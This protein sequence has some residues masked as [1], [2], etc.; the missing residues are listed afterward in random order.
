MY[1][2]TLIFRL[3]ICS[4][5]DVLQENKSLYSILYYLKN[6]IA[7]DCKGPNHRFDK[8]LVATHTLNKNENTACGKKRGGID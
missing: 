3:F 2:G 4:T 6:N 5:Q 8:S 7:M 1:G